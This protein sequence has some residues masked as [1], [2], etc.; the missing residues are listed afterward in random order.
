[1]VPRFTQAG[2]Y[3]VRFIATDDGDGTGTPLTTLV[4][5]PIVI[6]NANRAPVL[7]QLDN[8]HVAKGEV[9]VLDIAVTD[10][11]GNALTLAIDNLPRFATLTST[12]NGSAT[13]RL[14]PGERDRGDYVVTLTA[15]DDG[16]GGG[17]K[18]VLA[19]TRSFVISAD[20]ASEPPLLAAVGP[21]VAG[22][23]QPLRFPVRAGDLDQDALAFGTDLPGAT[24]VPGAAYGTALFE[25]TPTAAQRG[26]HSAKIF[27]NDT[28]GGRDEET[29][30]IVVRDT[31][32]A[33]LLLPVGQQT[34]RE[35]ELFTLALAAFDADGDT[36]TYAAAGLPPGAAFDARAGV[37]TWKPNL[38][39]AGEYGGITVSASDG[40]AS[41]SE[42]FAITVLQTNQAPLLAGIPP[43]GGQ[44]Q[45]LVQFSLVGTD[46]DGD[47]LIYEARSPLPAGAFF[48][49]ST[50][51]FE[52][53]PTYDQAGDY[54]FAFAARDASGAED[55]LSVRLAIADINRA[56]VLSLTNHL[57]QLGEPL[58]FRI[59]GTDADR[60][61]T[62][63]F[64]AQGLPEGASLN[65][66]TGE[67]SWTPGAGQAGDYL[68][69]VRVTDGKTATLRPLALRAA[70][71]PQRPD[72][73]I[74]LTPGFPVVPGQA[75]A[76]TVLADAFS[77][78][79]AKTLAIDGTPV[80]LDSRGRAFYTPG[81]S[82]LVHLQ[83]SATDLDGYTTVV[84][85]VLRVRDPSDTAA[86]SVAFDGSV[87]GR[88]VDAPFELR[89]RVLDSNLEA[90]T[91]EIARAGS[92]KFSVLARG[93]A[94]LDGVLATL[95][96]RAFENGLYRLRL[97]A[98][99]IAG[100][101]AEAL[102]LIEISSA[103]K[104]GRHAAAATDFSVALGGH[105]LEFVRRYDSHA[106]GEATSFGQGWSL[107]LRDV[108]LEADEVLR[109]GARLFLTAPDG[110]RVGFT[111][112][113]EEV[114]G[115]AFVYCTL[116]WIADAGHGW[117]LESQDPKL[118]R[119]AGR[120]YD[121]HSARPYQPQEYTLIGADETR[122]AIDPARGVTGITYADGARF[123]VGDSGI[124]AAGNEAIAFQLD[125]A[126]RIARV[127]APDGRLFDYAYD[128]EATWP[129]CAT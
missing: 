93:G 126:G 48:D 5:V 117:R 74:E 30:A 22:V 111:F 37:L 125:A 113:P 108:R 40:V 26:T 65:S 6:G 64:S 49:R 47:A 79:A 100:R 12:G 4:D 75:V 63:L 110:E 19:G 115:P 27:V 101:G 15:R 104:T 52:W 122:Y 67:F 73:A 9:K 60:N 97:S 116:R 84:E 81:A 45:R 20:S 17:A 105:T 92:D 1:M 87:A 51:L 44:E 80:A 109:A 3:S 112:E 33:P 99:D 14:A 96:P 86:P 114:R 88:Q 85:K 28:A 36:L 120:F 98:T 34:A 68:V 29:I 43:L 77:A 46:P 127:S 24:L 103:E 54:T 128:S 102:V 8:V 41:S 39:Q 71:Q 55:T 124:T 18:S 72:V 38:F 11:D 31:N 121:L 82:G 76:I 62:L 123:A 61:E 89:G 25:W 16:D 94:A 21:K 13:L 7:P 90:W 66:T 91:L 10:P 69:M 129:R 118:Q 35:G 32:A 78:V 119:A 50:G 53:T 23:G 107:A 58:A 95:D 57:A 2:T 83:A 106:A 59:G 56:P 42:T 70:Q